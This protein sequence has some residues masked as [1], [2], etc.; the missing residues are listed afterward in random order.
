MINC[1]FQRKSTIPGCLMHIV[2]CLIRLSNEHAGPSPCLLDLHY[3]SCPKSVRIHC[4]IHLVTKGI[5]F[6]AYYPG[7]VLYI[8]VKNVYKRCEKLVTCE[9]HLSI[10]K[11]VMWIRIIQKLILFLIYLFLITIIIINFSWRRSISYNF[12][13]LAST[14]V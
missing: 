6:S 2:K 8:A 13:N 14:S 1:L 10:L 4:F 12:N 11:C 5:L 9:C 3:K 7:T